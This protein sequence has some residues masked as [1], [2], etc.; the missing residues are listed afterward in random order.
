MCGGGSREGGRGD[1][2]SEGKRVG[3][4]ADKDLAQFAIQVRALNSVQMGIDPEDPAENI[5]FR[6]T[7]S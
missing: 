7:F 3:N 2:L 5:R 4:R 6:N 1:Y